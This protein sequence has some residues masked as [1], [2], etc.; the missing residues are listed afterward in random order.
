LAVFSNYPTAYPKAK[1]LHDLGWCL[2]VLQAQ[3][4][5]NFHGGAG[6]FLARIRAHKAV[7]IHA[8]AF[9][10][11]SELK[12]LGDWFLLQAVKLAMAPPLPC[13]L[14]NA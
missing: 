13:G 10:R 5:T 6:C 4:K 9:F 8:S 3:Y 1:W 2:V 7:A 12:L 14:N 11:V